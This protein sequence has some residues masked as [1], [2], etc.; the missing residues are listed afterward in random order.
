ME[1]SEA[2]LK[3][4]DRNLIKITDYV[5]ERKIEYFTKKIVRDMNVLESTVS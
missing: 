5:K 4:E 1:G 3:V 2:T